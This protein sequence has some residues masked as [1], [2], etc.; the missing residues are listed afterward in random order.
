MPPA[1]DHRN[2][3]G[4]RLD[5]RCDYRR[6]VA[7]EQ[8]VIRFSR[9]DVGAVAAAMRSMSGASEPG[10]WINIGPWLPDD[11]MLDVPVRSGLGAW[12]SGR[13]PHV[14]MAT[15][16]AGY[17][18]N[19][20]PVPAQIGIEHGTGPDALKRLGEDGHDLPDGWV[21]RQDHAK[22]GVVAELPANVV[23]ADVVL[24]LMEATAALCQ[25]VDPG[26]R[27]RAVVHRST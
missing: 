24:W 16:I 10:G 25:L 4:R 1:P 14:P 23:P 2:V 27:W 3:W 17:A 18:G 9:T 8:E 19:R 6:S 12:F 20:K 11:V 15:W 22:H 13:G 5:V 26:D 21:P 7:T